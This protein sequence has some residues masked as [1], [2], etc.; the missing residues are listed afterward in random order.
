MNAL[1]GLLRV[2]LPLALLIPASAKA[3]LTDVR[4]DDTI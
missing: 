4:G 2:T 1:L 3:R